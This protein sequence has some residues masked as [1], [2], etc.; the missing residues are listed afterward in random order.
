MAN[1]LE[2]IIS[3]KEERGFTHKI[4]RLF[5]IK[6]KIKTKYYGKK[7]QSECS[8]ALYDYLKDHDCHEDYQNLIRGLDNSSIDVVNK[9]IHRV[10]KQNDERDFVVSDVYSSAEKARLD[11]ECMESIK[12]SDKC[13]GWN[14]YF[15]TTDS[16]SSSVFGFKHG[17]KLLSEY[18]LN[19][20]K[21]RDIVDVGGYIGDS[22]ILLADYTD[23]NV[24]TFE[25]GS[26]NYNT[27]QET[28]KLNNSKNI[29]PIKLGLGSKTEVVEFSINDG[30]SKCVFDN[31]SDFDVE[32]I[33]IT[34]LDEYTEQN[35]IDVGLIKVDIE[36]LEQDFLKGARKTIENQKP[37][38]LLSIYHN[39]DDFFHIK[40]IIESWNLGYK[41]KIS[42][43]VGA[44]P[45]IETMLIAE[46]NE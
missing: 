35:N 32:K 11:E 27:L 4:I 34:T 16:F 10:I 15:L 20:V 29:V 33:N 44:E 31:K 21:N 19:R 38:L 8:E 14:K 6:F 18:S 43:H 37:V 46:V 45:L 39:P 7:F 12:F 1:L 40:T 17:L 30:E 26:N 22:A 3:I 5:G 42:K 13:Y 41:F 2:N 9:I 28:I 23:K 24:Y 36:G 25:P